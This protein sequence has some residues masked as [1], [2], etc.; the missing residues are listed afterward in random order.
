MPNS[1]PNPTGDVFVLDELTLS[2]GKS[3]SRKSSRLRMIQPVQRSQKAKVQRLL[4]FLQP[5]TYIRPHCHP[6]EQA[7]ESVCLLSGA[8]EVLIFN[9]HGSIHTRHHLTPTSPLIDIEPGVWHGMV[10]QAPDTVIFEVKEGPYNPKT[11]KK[12]AS[13]S[14]EEGSPDVKEFLA[15]L[16][17]G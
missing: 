5:G 15:R 2:K 7:T 10:V 6:L 16:Q 4:N 13:W 17:K 11:D 14:P 12:F 3:T 1:L 8:L 9:S